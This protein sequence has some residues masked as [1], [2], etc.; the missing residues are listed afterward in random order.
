M[1]IP[2]MAIEEESKESNHAHAAEDADRGGDSGKPR[3]MQKMGT[4][5]SRAETVSSLCRNPSDALFPQGNSPGS[6][7][8]RWDSRRGVA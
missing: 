1:T 2:D 7:R 3:E 6:H 4:K 8:I 5:H